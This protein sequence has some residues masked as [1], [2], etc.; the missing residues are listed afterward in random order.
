MKKKN[1]KYNEIKN[2]FENKK[3]DFKELENIYIELNNKYENDIK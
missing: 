1:Q 2:E 3:I